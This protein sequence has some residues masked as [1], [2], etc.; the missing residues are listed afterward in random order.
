MRRGENQGSFKWKTCPGWTGCGAPCPPYGG[1]MIENEKT[2]AAA[3]NFVER[4]GPDAPAEA[5]RRAHEMHNFGKAESYATWM[6]ILEQVRILL[7]DGAEKT[8]H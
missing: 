2:L 8:R 7:G 5:V 6:K 3:K 1:E 4:F